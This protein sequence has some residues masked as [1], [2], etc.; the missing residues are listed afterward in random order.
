MSSSER[1]ILRAS[2]ISA[3]YG[4]MKVVRGI[5]LEIAPGEV[6]A[7]IG[8]N[9]AGKTTTLLALGG[10]RYGQWAGRLTLGDEDLSKLTPTR[11]VARGVALVPEGHRI[12]QSLTVLENLRMGA[13]SVRRLG[14]AS[15]AASL[16]RVYELFPILEKYQERPAGYLSGGEQQMVAIG[17]ALMGRPRILMLDEPTSGLAPGVIKIIYAALRTLRD[18]GLGM[19]VVEQ[20]VDRALTQSDRFYVM[21]GGQVVASGLSST[22]VATR[23]QVTSIVRG[24]ALA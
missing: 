3:G 12:F 10:L 23:E 11:L 4:G 21:D 17:Q 15:I 9:G 24:I 14:K 5:D 2:G 7:L 6:V 1:S 16:D 13:I 19:L 20:S 22:D 8:R 18:D